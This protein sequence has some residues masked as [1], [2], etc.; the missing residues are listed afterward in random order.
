MTLIQCWTNIG[1]VGPTLYK[2]YTNVLYLL[3][4]NLFNV[5]YL[6]INF[7]KSLVYKLCTVMYCCTMA[8]TVTLFYNN[9]PPSSILYTLSKKY[10]NTE[11]PLILIK[12]CVAD[13]HLY[14]HSPANTKH[15]HNIYTM[16]DQRRRRINAMW[17]FCVCWECNKSILG[18]VWFSWIYIFFI[19]WSWILCWKFQMNWIKNKF[20][21]DED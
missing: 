21:Q 19:L 9:Y 20:S 4:T 8:V 2:S 10:K 13:A 18:D 11:I 3:G 15:L 1:D 16:L 7:S 17:M 5:W 14:R 6:C 12:W